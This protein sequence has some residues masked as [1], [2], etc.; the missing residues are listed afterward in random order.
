[1]N[2]YA[3][4]LKISLLADAFC[5]LGLITLSFMYPAKGHSQS[6]GGIAN[7]VSNGGFEDLYHCQMPNILNLAKG[8]RSIDSITSFP[9]VCSSCSGINCVP[10]SPVT[11]QFPRSG[12]NYVTTDMLCSSPPCASYFTRGYLRNR[13]KQTLVQGKKYCVKFYINIS[14]Y[15]TAGMDGFS[16]YFTD[17]SIDTITAG[18]V[19]LTYLSPQVNNPIGNIIT[20]TLN[21]VP[22]TGTFVA[23]GN[24]K[25]IIIGNFRSSIATTTLLVNPIYLPWIVTEAGVDDISCI[26]ID[27]PAYAGPDR[28]FLPGD[29]VYIGR[30]SD[31][32]ID[33]SCIWYNMTSPTTSVTIDTIAGLWVKPISTSTYVVR[34]QLWCS[35]VKWDTVVVSLSGVGI[36]ELEAIEND[37]SV[38]PNPASDYLQFQYTL[39]VSDPVKGCTIYN[40]LGQIIREDSIDFRNKKARIQIDDLSN[41]VYSIELRNSSGQLIKRRFVVAR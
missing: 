29:S 13:L 31:V 39:D 25:H 26:P 22:I 30:E 10:V 20:D 9:F 11:Y 2:R 1:M 41:G 40:S 32:E 34:Q 38:F 15:S 19:P 28:W 33:E 17:D 16:A 27:L 7:Y 3:R 6:G 21:W 35:G 36:N 5:F 23:N 37:F 4:P 24:E 8:W 12:S 18:G 14:N